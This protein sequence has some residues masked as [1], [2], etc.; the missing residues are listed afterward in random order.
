MEHYGYNYSQLVKTLI[1]KNHYEI[2]AVLYKWNKNP[3]RKIKYIGDLIEDLM[4]DPEGEIQNKYLQSEIEKHRLDL[5]NPIGML[6]IDDRVHPSIYRGDLHPSIDPGMVDLDHLNGLL[7]LDDS[8]ARSVVD[9]FAQAV[10]E[11]V[12]KQY[13]RQQVAA[14]TN[15]PATAPM[16]VPR[17]VLSDFLPPTA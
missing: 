17:I 10:R 11:Y 4:D 15:D 6:P 9:R 5:L 14:P 7:E 12:G 13:W 16:V 2:K 8:A 1:R 3:M